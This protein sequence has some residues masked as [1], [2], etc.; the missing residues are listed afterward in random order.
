MHLLKI[1]IVSIIIGTGCYIGL[2]ASA[3]TLHNLV[4]TGQQSTDSVQ[5]ASAETI[6]LD[7]ISENVPSINPSDSVSQVQENQDVQYDQTADTTALATYNLDEVVIVAS[8]ETR[9][10]DGIAYTPDKN[11]KKFATDGVSLLARMMIPSLRV[12]MI[13]NSVETS[14]GEGISYFI[15]GLPA[16]TEDVAVLVP[17]DVDKVEVLERPSDAK[18]LGAE[19][20]INYVVTKYL[21]GGYTKVR[22]DGS[23][24][25][26][27]GGGFVNS[28][29]TYKRMT[30][31]IYVN[32]RYDQDFSNSKSIQNLNI[33]G[34]DYSVTT[35]NN[36]PKGRTTSETGYFSA[37]YQT[38]KVKF[39]NRLS[40]SHSLT[41]WETNSGLTIYDTPTE[42]I[43][44]L[45]QYGTHSKTFTP[46]WDGN[47]FVNFPHNTALNVS[48]ST[49]FRL[50]NSHQLQK[51]FQNND[52]IFENDYRAKETGNF[53]S[54]F[55]YFSKNFND[56]HLFNVSWFGSYNHYNLNYEGSVSERN[57]IEDYSSEYTA[58]YTF[59]WNTGRVQISPCAYYNKTN[60]RGSK[61][62]ISQWTPGGS[63]LIM[64][65]P[66]RN[67]QL[68]IDAR[69]AVATYK[70]D[71]ID[72]TR[73]QRNLLIWEQGNPNLKACPAIIPQ[74]NYR[75]WN[76]KL[77]LNM[78][79][80]GEFILNTFYQ[81]AISNS[82]SPGLTLSYEDGV[83]WSRIFTGASANWNITN[84]LN[85]NGGVWF[86]YLQ[87]SAPVN[88]TKLRVSGALEIHWSHKNYFVFAGISSP[89]S[90]NGSD[91]FGRGA[92]NYVAGA[93]AVY[94][95]WSIDLRICNP[96]NKKKTREYWG[97]TPDRV[98]SFS[99]IT[100]S[101]LGTTDIQLSATYTI[102]YGRK[103][104][105]QNIEG[106][107]NDTSLIK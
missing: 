82:D 75:W 49:R 103:Q 67:Q 46:Q 35:I 12:N 8:R 87:K 76:Q 65:N 52:L 61:Y 70:L 26:W 44:A 101:N 100:Y 66:G 6:G 43:E 10:K 23:A 45:S 64:W 77:S 68:Y 74:I 69:F 98:Y 95:N 4:V 17:A 19:H 81:T 48:A 33:D 96:F 32:S 29:F 16:T 22:V 37:L 36:R 18:F 30:Y 60:V 28:G 5:S 14:S 34:N 50:N 59:L 31:S 53:S 71:Q 20:V 11:Q 13:N 57:R 47:L 40:L 83:N 79:V 27:R 9:L 51:Q 54:L 97:H 56:R 3:S 41:P 92:L 42:T 80:N 99:N 1:F 21:W 73:I 90:I 102:R 88:D 105:N 106:I 39:K 91:G 94:G 55:I 58:S 86:T 15:N 7:K 72:P 38:E 93:V 62:G 2:D 78:F 107:S 24:P 104:Q 85:I 25:S 89:S 84:E 63:A